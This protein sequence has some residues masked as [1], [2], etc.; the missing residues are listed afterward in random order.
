LW[1]A[2]LTRAASYADGS[3][4]VI[5]PDGQEKTALAALAPIGRTTPTLDLSVLTATEAKGL[6]FD[7]VIVIEPAQ[8]ADGTNTGKRLL[9]IA[10]TRATKTLTVLHS[11]PLP[12]A[13][14]PEGEPE[15]EPAPAPR[16]GTAESRRF[17]R[18]LLREQ[19]SGNCRVVTRFRGETVIR[20]EQDGW[21]FLETPTGERG[22]APA[23]EVRVSW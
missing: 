22:W 7:H 16:L 12:K 2:A 15:E 17:R 4:A 1:D 11:Q 8:I 13:I 5:V 18:L 19:P 3:V 23:T 21:L 9:L 6:E 10:L 20:Q 14:R